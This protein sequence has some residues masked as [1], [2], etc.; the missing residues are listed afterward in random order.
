MEQLASFG[1]LI[2]RRKLIELLQLQ[3]II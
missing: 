2:K 3:E 1:A